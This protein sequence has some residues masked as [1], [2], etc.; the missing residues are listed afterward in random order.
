MR[1]ALF[2]PFLSIIVRFDRSGS[3]SVCWDRLWKA[4]PCRIEQE[5]AHEG[6]APAQFK[7]KDATVVFTS[8]INCYIYSLQFSLKNATVYSVKR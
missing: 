1:L 4:R 2:P 5:I 6:I 8:Y 3:V 7:S